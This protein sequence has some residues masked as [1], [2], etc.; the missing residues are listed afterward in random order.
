[1]SIQT[2]QFVTFV[3]VFFKK[4]LF[5]LGLTGQWS[6]LLNNILSAYFHGLKNANIV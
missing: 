4:S 1:M 2:V 6:P 3:E 5:E